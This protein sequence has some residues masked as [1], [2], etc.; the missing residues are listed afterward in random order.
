MSP[1]SGS[2]TR[3][4]S[5]APGRRLP[6]RVVLVAALLGPLAACGVDGPPQPPAPRGAE[7][8]PPGIAVPGAAGAGVTGTAR[9]RDRGL[10]RV[11]PEGVP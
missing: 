10:A 9:L 4:A 11:G 5:A 2:G 8:P 1:V 3:S 6:L 7:A